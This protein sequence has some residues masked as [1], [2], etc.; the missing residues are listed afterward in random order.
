MKIKENNIVD[1]KN[2]L[3]LFY[4]GIIMSKSKEGYVAV[5]RGHEDDYYEACSECDSREAS[6]EHNF[7]P[8]CG[9]EFLGEIYIEDVNFTF[10]ASDNGEWEGLYIDGKL[11]TEGH[12]VRAIDV[13]NS[14]ADIL[15]NKVERIEVPSEIAENLPKNLKNL[16]R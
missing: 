10:V 6:V 3:V 7:C 13:I 2:K 1:N 4:G 8:N 5:H 11:A 12:C 16:K 15:P 14:I 9:V